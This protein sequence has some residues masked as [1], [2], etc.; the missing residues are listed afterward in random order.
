MRE[1]KLAEFNYKVLQTTLACGFNLKKW[2]LA[3]D[4]LCVM[5]GIQEDIVHMLKE[6]VCSHNIW[7]SVQ[8]A[9]K[10]KISLQD[11]IMGKGNPAIDELITTIAYIMYKHSLLRRNKRLAET[12]EYEQYFISELQMRINIYKYLG[13]TK[14]IYF[15]GEIMKRLKI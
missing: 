11:I 9:F 8:D 10:T 14:E 5:C 4:D 15:A 6:C 12:I 13:K 1:R 3:E 2:Q 7:D